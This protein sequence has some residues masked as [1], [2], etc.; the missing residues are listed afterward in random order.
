MGAVGNK[1]AHR[2][3]STR[4]TLPRL[5]FQAAFRALGLLL[6]F[7]TL[8]AR[9]HTT[10]EQDV[11]HVT[12][13]GLTWANI[14]KTGTRGLPGR[15]KVATAVGHNVVIPL[16]LRESQRLRP[17]ACIIAYQTVQPKGLVRSLKAMFHNN[18]KSI[19]PVLEQKIGAR[20]HI[21]NVQA[22]EPSTT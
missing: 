19:H 13:D 11:V 15:Q 22:V 14:A 1:S 9:G 5:D 8:R 10:M 20:L 18:Q 3:G 12:E 17:L 2:P 7:L 21:W 4:S 16:L 6:L